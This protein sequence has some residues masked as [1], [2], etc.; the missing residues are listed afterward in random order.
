MLY[1]CVKFQPNSFNSVQ[2]IESFTACFSPKGC[3]Q[4]LRSG[5]G[6]GPMPSTG[7]FKSRYSMLNSESE[8]GKAK[9]NGYMG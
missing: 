4:P 5:K 2:S 3:M 6:E 8:G 1:K 9:I 7:T